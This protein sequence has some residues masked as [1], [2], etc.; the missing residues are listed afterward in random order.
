MKEGM[1]IGQAT[2][3]QYASQ[4]LEE[5]GIRVVF[6]EHH[7]GEEGLFLDFLALH[8][9][10][11]AAEETLLFGSVAP[12]T[13]KVEVRTADA[14]WQDVE[15]STPSA[16]QRGT[17]HD[18]VRL[19]RWFADWRLGPFLP[20]GTY[21][22]RVR[23]KETRGKAHEIALAVE[24]GRVT[25]EEGALPRMGKSNKFMEM[26]AGRLGA[27][28]GALQGQ[29][30]GE[31]AGEAAGAK[32]WRKHTRQMP[33]SGRLFARLIGGREGA[34]TGRRVG[35][36]SA[37]RAAILADAVTAKAPKQAEAAS[38]LMTKASDSP[39]DWRVCQFVCSQDLA[40]HIKASGMNIDAGY[41]QALAEGECKQ[42]PEMQE[43]HEREAKHDDLSRKHWRKVL[44]KSKDKNNLAWQEI[45]ALLDQRAQARKDEAGRYLHRHESLLACKKDLEDRLRGRPPTDSDLFGRKIRRLRPPKK[46]RNLQKEMQEER[47]LQRLFAASRGRLDEWDAW[48]R[49]RDAPSPEW[50]EDQKAWVQEFHTMVDKNESCDRVL[51]QLLPPNPPAGTEAAMRKIQHELKWSLCCAAKRQQRKEDSSCEVQVD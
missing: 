5:Y 15:P 13:P 8:D 26:H 50:M 44:Q 14:A 6:E 34:E 4:G 23:E 7:N 25:R 51:Q 33:E 16:K 29:K 12:V 27:R 35:G 42:M 46:G 43:R 9:E 39:L 37:G 10:H 31:R 47:K 2:A 45:K 40:K 11:Q 36:D 20:T 41:E 24:N 28:T 22:I 48:V 3:R 19:V 1:R 32:V 30:E 18:A 49:T 17:G 21:N 38:E